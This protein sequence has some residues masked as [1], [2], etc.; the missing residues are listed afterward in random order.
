MGDDT[1]TEGTMTH[2]DF[3]DIALGLPQAV[4]GAHMGHPDLRVNGRIVA[5]ASQRCP[6]RHG[7]ARARRAADSC[8]SNRDVRAIERG[9]AVAAPRWQC[10]MTRPACSWKKNTSPSESARRSLRGTART[11][12]GPR[13]SCLRLIEQPGEG[14]RLS[15]RTA[16][17]RPAGLVEQPCGRRRPLPE[18]RQRPVQRGIVRSPQPCKPPLRQPQQPRRHAR[19]RSRCPGGRVPPPR[20]RGL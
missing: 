15:P 20:C 12:D 7:H 16:S 17:S 4:E 19:I 6:H 9:A 5:L 8:A 18:G 10:V 13:S 11:V 1:A 3:R 14:P 2:N